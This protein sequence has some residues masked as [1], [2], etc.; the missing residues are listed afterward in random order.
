MACFLSMAQA[1]NPVRPDLTLQFSTVM[2]VAH[3]YGH[4]GDGCVP[5]EAALKSSPASSKVWF[6]APNRRLAQTNPR[7]AIVDPDPGAT[8]VGLYDVTPATE[9]EFEEKSFG[10]KCFSSPLPDTYCQNGSQTCP[11]T[12]GK[13][14][15][16]FTPFTGI[17]GNNYL[18][19]SFLESTDVA[20][21]WQWGSDL[22]TLM[23]NGSYINITRNFTYIV[24]KTPRADGT[25]PLQS[26]RWTQSIPLRSGTK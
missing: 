10:V 20:D 13:F 22:P 26:F 17:L 6:D 2:Q 11:P 8:F 12:F 19:T 3:G 23:P 25:R 7:L 21:L 4:D 24:S 16:L 14:G 15:E 18:N 9:I 1:G 5:A